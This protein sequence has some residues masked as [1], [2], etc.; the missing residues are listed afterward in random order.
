MKGYEFGFRTPHL[1]LKLVEINMEN[2]KKAYTYDVY[3]A[4]QVLENGELSK[5]IS[6]DG[7]SIEEIAALNLNRSKVGQVI[8]VKDNFFYPNVSCFKEEIVETFEKLTDLNLL[9]DISKLAP[10]KK[11]KSKVSYIYGLN[12]QLRYACG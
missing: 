11:K 9:E 6:I 5:P 10:V 2:N 12:P 8:I 1:L 3:T 4:V 7:L